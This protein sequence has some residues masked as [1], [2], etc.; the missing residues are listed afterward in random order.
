MCQN[1]LGHKKQSWDLDSKIV[2]FSVITH[3]AL[4]L[5][6]SVGTCLSCWTHLR[7]HPMWDAFRSSGH[8]RPRESTTSTPHTHF[9]LLSSRPLFSSHNGLFSSSK[10]LKSSLCM[11]VLLSRKLFH[12]CAD[13]CLPSRTSSEEPPCH[14]RPGLSPVLQSRVSQ[15]IHCCHFGSGDSSVWGLPCALSE[16]SNIN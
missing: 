8:Q 11:C 3:A 9:N 7:S 12:H 13:S 15:A 6:R 10:T 1:S 4:S 16:V 5:Q 14:P 2:L